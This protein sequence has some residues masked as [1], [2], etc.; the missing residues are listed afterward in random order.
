MNNSFDNAKLELNEHF[1]KKILIDFYK[2]KNHDS[3]IN[4]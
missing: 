4:G 3:C 1:T 2:I